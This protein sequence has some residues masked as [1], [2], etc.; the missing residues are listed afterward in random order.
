VPE[1]VVPP[2][3]AADPAPA[4]PPEPIAAPEASAPAPADVPAAAASPSTSEAAP[5]P[6]PAATPE[7][8]PEPAPIP[9]E[10]IP[11][12][13]PAAPHTPEPFGA[14]A[15]DVAPT[16]VPA[17]AAPAEPAVEPAAPPPATETDALEPPKLP[18][19]TRK[20]GARKPEPE[21]DSSLDLPLED[22]AS[23]GAA[24]QVERTLSSDGATR[25]I[26]TA[27]IGIG[28]RLF[29]RGDGPGLSWDKGVPL[30][31]VSIG[32]WRWETNDAS[33]PIRFKLFKNDELECATLG[34]Q[35]LE[36]GHL[37]ELLA[38]F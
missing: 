7:P 22:T 11:E 16:P 21:P 28:N 37:Q 15:S 25:L 36:P 31:F 9:E 3:A 12:I 30:Q 35:I 17:T 38:T 29:I 14:V 8:A 23:N 5:A 26:A 19:G 4:T 32:K 1:P 27:Y 2:E 13:A 10:T 33:A 34:E 24:P 6:E 20:R 18:A